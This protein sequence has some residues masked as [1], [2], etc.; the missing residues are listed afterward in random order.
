MEYISSNTESTSL[1]P[2]SNLHM[3]WILQLCA[4]AWDR[5]YFRELKTNHSASQGSM[6]LIESYETAAP[7]LCVKLAK[8]LQ[9]TPWTKIIRTKCRK[10]KTFMESETI[11]HSVNATLNI[12]LMTISVVLTSQSRRIIGCL[13]TMNPDL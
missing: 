8:I 1:S 2:L 11:N 13:M 9:I 7:N 5:K 4:A 12:L 6:K 3:T 10:D